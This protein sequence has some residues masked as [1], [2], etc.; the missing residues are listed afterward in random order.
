MKHI[1]IEISLSINN[2][3][4]SRLPSNPNHITHAVCHVYM[5]FFFFFFKV[6]KYETVCIKY[7]KKENETLKEVT[8][9]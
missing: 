3:R 8:F 6:T 1:S 2:Q 7:H 9:K 4:K 5:R